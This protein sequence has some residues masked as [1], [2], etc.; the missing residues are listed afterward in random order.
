MIKKHDF[1]LS[2]LVYDDYILTD[3]LWVTQYMAT[4]HFKNGMHDLHS[5]V[6]II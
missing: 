6:I 3:E 5:N 2:S 1:I 4:G